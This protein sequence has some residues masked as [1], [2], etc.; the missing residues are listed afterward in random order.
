MNLFCMKVVTIL[1]ALKRVLFIFFFFLL[2]YI[3]LLVTEQNEQEQKHIEGNIFI[4]E[5]I[6][7][8][9]NI[10]VQKSNKINE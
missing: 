2:I 6:V 10:Q 1:K 9:W 8:T 4:H 7:D 5:D 3:S